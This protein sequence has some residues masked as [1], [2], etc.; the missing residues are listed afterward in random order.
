MT[1]QAPARPFE[2]SDDRLGGRLRMPFS[3]RTIQARLYLAFTLA[4]SLTVLGSLFALLASTS[5]STTL[6]RIAFRSMPATVESFR[7]SEEVNALVSLAPSLMST[8]NEEQRNAVARD[9]EAQSPTIG[10]TIDRL[11]RLDASQSD[12]IEVARSAMNERFAALN[13]AVG[14][15]IKISLQRRALSVAVRKSHEQLLEAITPV[16]DDANFDLMTK[17]QASNKAELNQAIDSLRRLLEIQADSNLLAGLLIESSL[18]AD[19]ASLPPMRDLIAAAERNIGTNLK[20]LPGSSGRTQIADLYGKLAALGG[21]SGI[22]VQRTN[23]LKGNQEAQQVYGAALAEAKR[24]RLAV[25]D[26][27]AQQDAIAQTLSARAISQ[28]Q[29]GRIVL[30]VLSIAA[31]AGAGLIAWLYVGRSIV[32]RL[33]LLNEAMRKIAEGEADVSVPIGGEDEIADMAKALLVFRQAIADVSTARQTEVER[34]RSAVSRRHQIEVATRDFE[35]TVNDI[36]QALHGASRTMDDCAQIMVGVTSDNLTQADATASASEEATTNVGSVAAA[37]EEIALS[38]A[39]ISNRARCSAEMARRTSEEARSVVSTVERLVTT[40]SQINNVSSFIRDIAAQTNLLALNATIEAARA[41]AAGRGF[42]VVAQEV[43]TLAT[44]T[45]KATGDIAQQISSIEVT[46]ASVV[47]AMKAIAG[48]IA[49]LEG[50]ANEISVAVEQQDSVSKEIARN[51]NA[52]AERT[53]EVSAS[54]G[55]V[56]SAANKAKQVANAVFDAGSGLASKSGTLR[57]EVERF[58]ANVRVA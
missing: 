51:A 42:A 1:E 35:S 28:M 44:Q 41:G 5:I 34:G 33:L 54:V 20:A 38:V 58:I 18:V 24:L 13:T 12:E 25:D 50:H 45:E 4:A 9:I 57:I 22:I 3:L 21:D 52:A 47:H 55:Q 29:F 26:L 7:L 46:T 23:E 43:K 2:A 40:V 11:R 36:I 15:R 16:I 27:I 37:A 19:I 14:A 53:R 48:Q 49:E 56:S 39:Q 30:I 10:A 8:E 6:T 31:L 17:S 32:R